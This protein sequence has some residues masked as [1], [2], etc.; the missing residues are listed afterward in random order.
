MPMYEYRCTQCGDVFE[1]IQKFSD[2]PLAVHEKCG[3]AVERLISAPG[4]QFKGSG[5]Y[6]TDYARGGGTKPK[7][8]GAPESKDSKPAADGA[9]KESKPAESK[10]APASS[11]SE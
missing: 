11:K 4:L 6:I 9:A 2:A 10:P 8:E 1:V 7:A 3:G 5:W